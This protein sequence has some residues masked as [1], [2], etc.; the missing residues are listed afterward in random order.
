[1]DRSFTIIIP[2]HNEE[3]TV[4]RVVRAAQG[5]TASEIIV[6]DDGSSDGTVEAIEV[7]S[8]T[9][10]RIRLLSHEKNEGA[11]AAR[12][13]GIR[14]SSTPVLL[15]FDADIVT[16]TTEHMQMIVQPILDNA[17]DFVLGGFANF[18]RV[19]EF[20]MRPLLAQLV[21][22]LAHISQPLSGLFAARREF[23]RIESFASGHAISGI[24]LDV[25]FAHA[26][27]G[28]VHIGEIIH[29]KRPDAAKCEQAHSECKVFVQKLI[30]HGVIAV[31]Q[32]KTRS[33]SLLRDMSRYIP[34]IFSHI[35]PSS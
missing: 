30:E 16:V 12:K 11:G 29:D 25:H 9:D 28:E 8:A 10:A 24:L 19:T 27:V 23:L 7:L 33:W 5:T 4:S 20:L 2:A 17:F 15:F 31:H 26:R 32:E 3:Q 35:R 22:E 21:P 18:G 1:M 13:T 14:A 6:I 34:N